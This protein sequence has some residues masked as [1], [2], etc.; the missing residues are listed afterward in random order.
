[1]VRYA[2]YLVLLTGAIKAQD[3]RPPVDFPTGTL[4]RIVPMTE[5]SRQTILDRHND[6]RSRVALGQLPDR[7]GQYV[8]APKMLKLRYDLDLEN[9]AEAFAQYCTWGHSINPLGFNT[10]PYNYGE[11]IYVSGGRGNPDSHYEAA[12]DLWANEHN[13]YSYA[14]DDC[15]AGEMCGHFTQVVWQ[16]TARLGCA[17]VECDSFENLSYNGGTYVVCTYLKSGNLMDT[18]PIEQPAQVAGSGCDGAVVDGLCVGEGG[19]VCNVPD[20]GSRCGSG[21]CSA[22]STD[23]INGESTDFSCSCPSDSR[24]RWCEQT[25]CQ[26]VQLADRGPNGWFRAFIPVNGVIDLNSNAGGY[27]MFQPSQKEQALEWCKENSQNEYGCQ[28]VAEVGFPSAPGYLFW[29][30]SSWMRR[31]AGSWQQGKCRCRLFLWI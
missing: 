18:S 1:M 2:S 26:D 28:S 21:S 8:I 16:S 17:L 20:I 14:D 9:N 24:G 11:N 10:L 7:D 31:P 13:Y 12:V 29:I 22:L 5:A 25:L 23:M 30:P 19:D 15:L 27:F 3:D 4:G 6:Y